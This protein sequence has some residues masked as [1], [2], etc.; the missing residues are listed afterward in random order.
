MSSALVVTQPESGSIGGMKLE[1]LAASLTSSLSLRTTPIAVSVADGVPDGVPMFEGAIAAGCGFW[2]RAATG[3]FAT[4]TRD[5]EL[6]AIGVHTHA[7]PGASAQAQEELGAVLKVMADLDYVRPED[8]AG[9]PV[10]A[11]P[12]R[13]VIYAPLADAPLPP[14]VVLLFADGR[15]GLVLSEAAQMVDDAVPP[16]LGRPACAIVPQAINSGRAAVSLGCCGARAYLDVLTDDVALWALP[17]AKLE[18]YTQR[19]ASL[20]SDNSTLAK[21]HQ[22]RRLDVAAGGRPSLQQSLDRLMS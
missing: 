16:A 18:A 4:V 15:Q 7:M 12:A 19:I 14:D 1:E 21:F 6:C 2:E 17:G 20:A 22:L 11:R 10:L 9:I 8:V 5:H 13:H 3:A